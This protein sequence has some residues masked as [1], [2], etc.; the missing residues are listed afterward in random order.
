[1][2]RFVV[3]ARLHPV[4]DAEQHR[5]QRR[6]LLGEEEAATTAAWA[7]AT[8]ASGSHAVKG[9]SK[10]ASTGA[11]R[12]H[13]SLNGDDGVRTHQVSLRGYTLREVT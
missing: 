9:S 8:V 5:G 12:A 6:S 4:R 7:S 1:M 3:D 10:A 13:D 11:R 2:R